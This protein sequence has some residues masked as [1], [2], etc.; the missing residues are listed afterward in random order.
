MYHY[1]LKINSRDSNYKV[2]TNP[3]QVSFNNTGNSS[4]IQRITVKGACIPNVF[5]NVTAS[6]NK[7][8]IVIDSVTYNVVF[9]VGQYTVTSLLSYFNATTVSAISSITLTFNSFLN[10]IV[11]NSPA[12]TGIFSGLST[13]F[14]LIGLKPNEDFTFIAGATT[15]L[16]MPDLSGV[17]NIYA[18]TSFSNMHCLDH[19]G[20]KSYGAFIPVD[21]PFGSIV[22]YINTEQDLNDIVRSKVYSQNLNTIEIGLRDV[23]GNMLDLQNQPWE[24]TF[25]I[26]LAHEHDLVD[27]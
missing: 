22:H 1:I 17:R 3:I 15:M 23:Y 6:N 9:P 20:Y 27:E 8:D 25:K 14:H 16:Y 24:I 4:L 11:I 26:V 12:S 7:L 18:E 10:K 5:Y 21:K 2:T 19:T 13:C